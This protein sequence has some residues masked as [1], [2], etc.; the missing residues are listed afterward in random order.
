M[1]DIFEAIESARKALKEIQ[2]LAN[3]VE[4]AYCEGLIDD[5]EWDLNRKILEN[6]LQKVSFNLAIDSN[7]YSEIIRGELNF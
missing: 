1:T 5:K 3:D 2:E 6:K 4:A 7:A